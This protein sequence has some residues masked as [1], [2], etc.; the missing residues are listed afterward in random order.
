MTIAEYQKSTEL[1]LTVRR[2]IEEGYSPDDEWKEARS[3]VQQW[4][5]YPTY[6]A[7]FRG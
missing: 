1:D 5:W 2:L 3:Q 4:S 6:R 7:R